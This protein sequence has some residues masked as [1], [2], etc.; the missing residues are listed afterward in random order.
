M[1]IFLLAVLSGLPLLLVGQKKR[2]CFTIDDL[3]LVTYGIIDSVYQKNLMANLVDGLVNNKIP[4]IGFV[5]ETK[6]YHE[7]QLVPFRVQL[8]QYWIENGLELGNHTFSH[9]DYNGRSLKSFGEDVVKGEEI[10]KQILHQKGKTLTYFRHPFLHTGSTKAKHDSLADFLEARNYTVA[11]VTIDDDDYLF[12]L[13][14][15]RAQDKDDHTLMKQIGADY[16]AYMEKKVLHFEKQAQG[17]FGR[18]IS[19]ILL[20][21]ANQLNADYMPHLA[22]V[23]RQNNYDFIALEKALQDEAYTTPVTVF[24]TWGISWLDRWALSQ[25]K[26]GDFFKNDPPTPEYIQNLAR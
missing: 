8:L 9:P 4:A 22:E 12:A 2:V 13:A 19:Q 7:D 16:I 11:P 20:I 18:N 5:N 14:Y 3:P 15:K 23:F 21:H 10:T 25:G 1:R 17:V 26:K 6:L 24:G